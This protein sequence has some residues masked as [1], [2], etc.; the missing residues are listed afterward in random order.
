VVKRLGDGSYGVVDAVCRKQKDPL[1]GRTWKEGDPRN[2]AHL[3]RKKFESPDGLSTSRSRLQLAEHKIMRELSKL[4]DHEQVH[5]VR[6]ELTYTTNVTEGSAQYYMVISPIASQGN[7]TQFLSH[8]NTG[9]YSPL[10]K[11][12]GCLVTGLAILHNA[13]IRH[14]DLHPGNILIHQ[15]SP[16]Y[17]DFGLS[18]NFKN[19]QDSKTKENPRHHWQFAAPEYFRNEERGTS[20]DV[21]GLGGIL[22]EIAAVLTKDE[23]MLNCRPTASNTQFGDES[24]SKDAR[25][26]LTK[27]KA[28]V[29]D[30]MLRCWLGF[31]SSMLEFSPERRPSAMDIVTSLYQKQGGVLMCWS[32]SKWFTEQPEYQNMDKD[33]DRPG[34]AS[35]GAPPTQSSKPRS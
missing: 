34:E 9:A 35:T 27:A 14:H 16:L 8:V 12:M 7:L 22:Y 30:D 10:P 33:F 20:A 17:S 15:D 4:S 19:H 31:I 6:H 29:G 11:I 21:F 13:K 2:R 23:D 18:Y 32:C 25:D 3:A 5:L 1:T 28:Y 26:A 24:E